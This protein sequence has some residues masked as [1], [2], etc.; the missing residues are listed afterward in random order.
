MKRTMNM[1]L[2]LLA[3]LCILVPCSSFADEAVTLRVPNL[4]Y[5]D[6][7]ILNSYTAETGVRFA[8]AEAI[9]VSDVLAARNDQI[10]LFVLSAGSGLYAIKEH[11]YYAPLENDPVL[12]ARMNDLY[13]AFQKALTQDGHIVG[14]VVYAQPM[15]FT[16]NETLL[17]EHGLSLPATFDELLDACQSLIDQDVID[18]RTTLF[19]MN[20]YTASDMLDLYM[21]EYIRACALTGSPVDFTRPE[22]AATAERIRS[23]V[24]TTALEIDW[25]ELM[26][27]VFVYPAAQEDIYEGMTSF[28]AVLSD[29]SGAVM[30][31][32]H[33][34]TVNPYAAHG[35]EA[36]AFLS[37]YADHDRDGYAYDASLTEPMKDDWAV[38]QLQDNA[39][40]LA[41]LEDI[42][43]PTADQR[44][45]IAD[46]K[47]QQI[48]LEENLWRVS[49]EAIASYRAFAQ[50]LVVS[51][52]S[53][54]SYDDTLHMNAE[55][56]LNGAYDGEVFA[57]A[58]QDHIAMIYQEHSIPL[59]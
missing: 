58:C 37:Y 17:S 24:P 49:E 9:D 22:F 25:E 51:D 54:I 44:D 45:Q 56:F 55:R 53:P 26:Y 16:A 20:S 3:I 42:D 6:E 32:M 23:Q 10:D 15:T 52:G 35:E 11:G 33:A 50:N 48:M 38:R 7:S 40:K 2:T 28:P 18:Q 39:V 1:L 31:M 4:R 30:T 41:V 36:I 14:W 21:N 27:E 34:I 47:E 59:E 43:E 13:P 29:Q 46:L 8:E 19:M 12:A 57:K 5:L